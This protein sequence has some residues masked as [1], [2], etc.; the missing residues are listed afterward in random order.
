M[1]L[2]MGVMKANRKDGYI[3]GSLEIGMTFG[4]WRQKWINGI[5]VDFL[6]ADGVWLGGIM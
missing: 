6:R 2:K 5:G 1:K 3:Y 4:A